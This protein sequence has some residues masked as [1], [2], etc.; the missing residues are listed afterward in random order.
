MVT[1]V[2]ERK[3]CGVELENMCNLMNDCGDWSDERTEFC[4][5]NFECKN[6]ETVSRVISISQRCNGKSSYFITNLS[7]CYN[8]SM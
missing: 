5:N 1:P 3:R 8:V 2:S 7:W 6:D 4:P